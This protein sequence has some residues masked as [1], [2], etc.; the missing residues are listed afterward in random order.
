MR[1]L[2][3]LLLVLAAASAWAQ[4]PFITHWDVR[5]YPWFTLPVD[6]DRSGYD[7]VVLW[8]DGTT[9]QW[10]D[11]DNPSRLTKHYDTGGIY[12]VTVVGDF[13]A[14]KTL[15]PWETY[16][17]IDDKLLRVDQWGDIEWDSM[18]CAFGMA[19]HMQIFATDAPDLSGV[20]SMAY[21]FAGANAMNSNLNHWDVSAVTDM[22]GA[23]MGV[24]GSQGAMGFNGDISNWDVSNV[25][26]MTDMFNSSYE[27]NGDISG[28][29]VSNVTHMS[30][31]F[32]HAMSFNR[33]LGGWNVGNVRYMDSMFKT[34]GNLTET[35]NPNVGDWDVSNVIS[36][37][38][39]FQGARAFSRDLG[40]W[41]IG[42]VNNM[43]GMFD[44]SGMSTHN[45]DATLLGWAAQSPNIQNGVVVGVQGLEYCAGQSARQFLTNEH[46][47]SFVGDQ[48]TEDCKDAFITRWKTDNPGPSG[49]KQIT[50]PIHPDEYYNFSINW[51][52]GSSSHWKSG[53][54]PDLLTHTYSQPGTY[55]VHIS[56]TFPRIYFNFEG[57]RQ[58]ILNVMAWGDI[59][60]T[61]MERAFAGAV[62]MNVFWAA[63]APDL[64]KVTTTRSMFEGASSLNV[65]L[66]HWNVYTVEQMAAMF[67]DAHAFNGSLNGWNVS[68]VTNMN[69]MFRQAHAFNSKINWSTYNVEFMHGMFSGAEQFNQ[70][71]GNWNV[72]K[73]TAMTEMFRDAASFDH[74]LGNWNI[75][76]VSD[77]SNMLSG[78]G[79]SVSSYDATLSGWASAGFVPPF[80]ALGADG[81]V[82]CAAVDTRQQ[83]IDNHWWQIGG[84][85]F[86][87]DAEL[88]PPLQLGPDNLSAN[89]P[90]PVE[91]SWEAVEQADIYQAQVV[92]ATGS[93]D[94]PLFDSTTGQTHII[95]S[96][97]EPGSWYIWRVRARSD[98]GQYSDWSD[99][100]QFSTSSAPGPE[101]GE[102]IFR[103][104]FED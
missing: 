1:W 15:C 91:L 92:G 22:R 36:M 76:Q 48:R 73:V 43:E 98:A 26:D 69:N 58:K 54:N 99:I 64:S 13:P 53:D 104:R 56:G 68:N 31:M 34:P 8:G 72:G 3:G 30:G 2:I 18:A 44:N 50:I 97:L 45:Y 24:S 19:T 65:D 102:V 89:V 51:G 28:W 37:K 66:N 84:D 14:M 83:L 32:E 57:D 79:L 103:D 46:G 38:Q 35:F 20:S 75:Q 88:V 70:N 87:N 60:W 9:T 55:Q 78:A 71:I 100:W 23:F 77:M 40:N 39:M 12:K 47:W 5:N 94:F 4:A 7:F 27:F 11:G 49:D 74:S 63:G 80:I 21:M 85:H 67:K 86:C 25:T 59:E 82:Y 61:S 93:F 95:V 101:P 10:R 52:D 62:N 16:R 96:G 6:L 33:D 29:D 90:L 41:N 42:K 81:L 17:P